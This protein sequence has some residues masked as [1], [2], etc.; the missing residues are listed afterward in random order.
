ML[1]HVIGVGGVTPLP[2]E[3][4]ESAS[5]APLHRTVTMH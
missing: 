5:T 1:L 4:C 3:A 2:S